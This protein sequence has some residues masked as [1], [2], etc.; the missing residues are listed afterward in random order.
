MNTTVVINAAG[1]GATLG[2][3]L[4]LFFNYFPRVKVWY[5]ALSREAKSGIMIGAL[6]AVAVAELLRQCS[7][8]GACIQMNWGVA[9]TAFI[10]AL[11]TNQA[12]YLISPQTPS[13][14]RARLRQR[15]IELQQAGI[16]MGSTV[17]GTSVLRDRSG[18][19]P[20]RPRT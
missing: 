7:L 13:V 11:I 14:K 5:A 12:T 19:I 3:V 15:V 18:A 9:G 4:S 16:G 17:S 8:A 1:L 10:S 2:L 20:P 6:A